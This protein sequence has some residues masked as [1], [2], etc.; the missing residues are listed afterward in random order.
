MDIHTYAIVAHVVGAV[1]GVGTVTMHDLHLYRAIGDRDLAVAFRKSEV[2]YNRLI[3]IGLAL[4]VASGLYFMF[5]RPVLWSSDKILTKLGLVALLVINGFI[6]NFILRSKLGK[7]SPDDWASKSK[8]LRKVLMFRLPFDAISF[9]GWYTVLFLGAVG[10]QPWSVLTII[11][12]YLIFY[13]VVYLAF[14][15]VVLKRF[16]TAK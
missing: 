3:Q 14:R 15:L 5:S 6:I 9:S 8:I 11:L 10:R 1:L 7:L 4:L 2:F 12:G 16:R 13:L